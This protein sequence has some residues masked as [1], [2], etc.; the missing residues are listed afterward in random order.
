MEH[1]LI[2]KTLTKYVDVSNERVACARA[3][4][5]QT[6]QYSRYQDVSVVVQKLP[7]SLVLVHL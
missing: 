1:K 2:D 3:G 5:S 4:P 7:S 6:L